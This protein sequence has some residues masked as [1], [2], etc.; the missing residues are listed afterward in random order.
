MNRMSDAE[1]VR[2]V[3]Q[4]I[5]DSEQKQQ[6]LLANQILQVNRD[7]E[8][9]RRN[10]VDRMLTAYRQLQG[11][12]FETSQRVRAFEDHLVRVGLQR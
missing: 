5:S 10:D 3:R 1:I 8:T 12:S 7:T 2:L 11:A 4:S 9:A 6:G